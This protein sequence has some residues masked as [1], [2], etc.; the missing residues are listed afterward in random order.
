M[1]ILQI[2]F[3]ILLLGYSSIIIYLM[4][5][6][7]DI[8]FFKAN[9]SS[10]HTT[11]SI[12]IPFRNEENNLSDLLDH[13]FMQDY[14]SMLFEIILI[15]DF[16][17]DNSLKIIESKKEEAKQKGVN[18]KIINS[19]SEN[20]K[21]AL[22]EGIKLAA[23]ELIITTDADCSLAPN[24]LKT[25]VCYY[26]YFNFDAASAPV[27]FK[28]TNNLWQK[29]QQLEFIS[30]ISS[31]AASIEA[32]FPLMCNGANLVYKKSA[33]IDAGGFDGIDNSPSGDD[34]LLFQKLSQ[35]KKKLVFIKSEDAFVTTNASETITEFVQQRKRWA[36]KVTGQF[37][38]PS[39]IVALV[40]YLFSLSILVAGIG[41]F[42]S[43]T[44]FNAFI[45][46]FSI[47]LI[48]DFLFFASVLKF[49]KDKSLLFL[50]LPAEIL[51]ILYVVSIGTIAP[52]GKYNWKG[53]SH[54]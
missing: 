26:Q 14:P 50:I 15:N 6:W 52:F 16:S 3:I 29:L 46:L 33:F 51:Y 49:F 44:M 45:F 53:R 10:Y 25:I 19:S 11:L 40:V 41:S 35:K 12:I 42:F 48:V 30:L 7:N 36:S 4:F 13:L 32:G 24:W 31:G 23:G 17:T 5:K 20:K 38:F 8:P 27:V 9:C 34:V 2:V 39:F 43:V 18:L 47:K 37:Y 21:A 22:T 1:V 28:K 54:R